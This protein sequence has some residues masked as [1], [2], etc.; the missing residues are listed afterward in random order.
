MTRWRSPLTWPLTVRVPAAVAVLM[1]LVATAM[2][3]VILRRLTS[4]Q[5][6]HLS[7]LAG[8]YLDGLS[9]AIAPAVLRQDVWEAFDALDRARG[10]YA[11]LT[12]R[13]AIVAL[14]GRS[15][16]A[17]SDPRS[18]PVGDP[19]TA[20]LAG[21][22]DDRRQLVIDDAQKTALL[23]RPLLDS[24]T[25]I[26]HLIAEVDIAK[27]LQVR[28]EVLRTLVLF[29]AGL[30]LLFA[31][32]GYAMTRR[33]VGPIKLLGVHVERLRGGR[34][35]AIPQERLGDERTEFGRLFHR[36][37]AMAAAIGE[38]EALAQRLA[39]EEKVYLLGKLTS[40]MAHEVNNP[41]GGMVNAVDTLRKHGDD[42]DVRRRSLDLLERGL[43]G[44][45]N[46]VR[47]AL[48]T[49]KG[50][51]Q[52]DRLTHGD[53]DDLR[54]LVRHETVRRRIRLDWHNSLPATLQVDGAAVRQIVLNLLLNACAA[55]PVGGCV[56]VAAARDGDSVRFEIGDEGPGLPPDMAAL[57]GSASPEAPSAKVGLGLWTAARLLNRIGGTVAIRTAPGKG[58]TLAIV[59]PVTKGE[60]LDAVA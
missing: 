38:R 32:V 30:A 50:G 28:R 25:L 39:G 54:Y 12:L 53:I 58:T 11:G 48:V 6:A 57:L 8:A 56:R 4:D 51:D 18:F 3:T 17:S 1:I 45:R 33:M 29:N 19:V 42:V 22:L 59:V 37:N 55:S 16:L 27:L 13:Y 35:E 5:E 24:G 46:V 41:L 21:R 31:V 20:A 44:I 15:V 43:T 9:T 36:F 40:S 49:Y 60:R 52:P 34:V 23:H 14:P 47:A 7:E 10:R 26:G 2:S